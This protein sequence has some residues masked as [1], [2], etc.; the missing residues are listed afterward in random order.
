[1][2]LRGRAAPRQH[3]PG[4]ASARRDARQDGICPPARAVTLAALDQLLD[5]HT[6]AETAQQLNAAGH[7]SGEGKPFTGR[8]VLELRRSNNLPS[9]AERL[10]GKRTAHHRRRAGVGKRAFDRDGSV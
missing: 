8:I 6:D 1:M 3:L 2:H 9:H 7:R 10:R 5:E 4:D